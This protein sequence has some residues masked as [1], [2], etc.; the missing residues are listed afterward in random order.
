MERDFRLLREMGVDIRNGVIPLIGEV[1]Q[2]MHHYLVRVL[3]EISNEGLE[4]EQ[5]TIILNTFGGDLYSAFGIKNLLQAQTTDVRIVCNGPVMSAGTVILLGGNIREMTPDSYLMV[6]YGEDVSEG[7]RDL[8]QNARLL[9][10]MKQLYTEEST[11]SSRMVSKWFDGNTY[12]N[13]DEA[14]KLGLIDRV[15]ANEKK[16]RK[17][18]AKAR[19]QR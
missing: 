4:Y 11:V 18:R 6:H 19:R 7:E 2:E 5:L 16:K 17:K 12:Y 14:L 3:N 9:K 15:T 13:A 8:K 10:K 1:G